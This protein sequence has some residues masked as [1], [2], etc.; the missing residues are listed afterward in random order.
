MVSAT[1]MDPECNKNVFQ[2]WKARGETLPFKVIRWTWNP[3]TTAFLVERIEIGKWPY[4]KAWGR[5]IRNGAP[6]VSSGP[7]SNAGS[8]QWKIA[9]D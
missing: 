7:L 6:E 4:G 1:V 9:D 5:I 3:A 8:Y 2:I